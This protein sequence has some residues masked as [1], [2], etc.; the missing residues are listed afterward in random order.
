MSKKLAII[1]GGAAGFFAGI[2]AA[3]MREDMEVHI[4][5]KAAQFL[6]KV[7][8][9]GGGRCNVTHACFDPQEL[10]TY[11]PRGSREL[12]GPFYVFNP[13]DTIEWFNKRRVQIHAEGDGRMFPV[14]NTSQTIIDCFLQEAEYHKVQLHTQMGL[15]SLKKL[16]DN[17]WQLDFNHGGSFIA[18]KV[19]IASGS[20]NQI[21]E[22]L[23]TMGHTI[24]EPVPSLFTFHIKDKRIAELMGV[25]VANVECT[26]PGE[27]ITTSGPL[28]IT[29]WGLSG[30]AI[31]KLSAWAAVILAK[32]EYRF[33]FI[34]N[35]VPEYSFES[36]LHALTEL[37]TS[38]PKKHIVN[39]NFGELP[40]R[41]W[42]SICI[43]CGV[44]DKLNWADAKKE[45]LQQL[46]ESLTRASFNVT[47]KSTF[48]DEVVTCGGV[49]LQEVDLRSM[50][51]KLH[52][53]LYFAGE[54]LNIDAV[55]GGFNFQAAWTTGFIAAT[56]ITQSDEIV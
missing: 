49:K 15:T 28:L 51:S 5:D 4:F 7:K 18:D 12:L 3:A 24:V 35:F 32:K 52:S 16:P 25:S 29:H 27:K 9:S 45:T 39:H 20:S 38:S 43:Y 22:I 46:A 54:V 50:E 41:L 19:L 37:K 48:K 14:T 10:V 1:G 13:A 6:S 36:C 40:S 33:S 56:H 2:N 17:K 31:L 23:K 21:W 47:G 42:K 26:I 8:V 34:V 11:Y 44:S 53:G 30:P 55:T